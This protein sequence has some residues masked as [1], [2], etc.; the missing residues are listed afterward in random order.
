ME[1]GV[2]FLHM[3]YG[4][5]ESRILKE[6]PVFDGLG[7]ECEILIYYPAC[8]YV[9]MADFRVAHLSFGKTYI[10]AA[11]LEGGVGV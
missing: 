8:T 4:F 11:R 10:E 6:I 3:L 9:E 5:K 2:V 1:R 7:D